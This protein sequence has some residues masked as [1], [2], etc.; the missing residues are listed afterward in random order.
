MTRL[1]TTRTIQ[2]AA[3]LLLFDI[4]AH[5][6]LLAFIAYSEDLDIP[7]S[8]Y[9]NIMF[10]LF[11]DLTTDLFINMLD[12]AAYPAPDADAARSFIR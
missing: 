9:R 4:S 6:T 12:F 10:Q 3:L 7:V 11:Y 2:D 1:N 5:L 8:S